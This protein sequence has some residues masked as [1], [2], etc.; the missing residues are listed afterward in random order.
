MPH[1]VNQLRKVLL[2]NPASF[3]YKCKSYIL[4]LAYYGSVIPVELA[5]QKKTEIQLNTIVILFL[6]IEKTLIS[7]KNTDQ[8]LRTKQCSYQDSLT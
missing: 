4:G 3:D 8:N 7:P 2:I 5:F 1:P 6:K